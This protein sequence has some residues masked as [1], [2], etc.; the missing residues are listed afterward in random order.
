MRFLTAEEVDALADTI[1][2]RY[3][4]L[5]L[6]LG[7]CGLR[8]GE[9]LALRERDVDFIGRKVKVRRTL[10]DT[11]AGLGFGDPKTEQSTRE[12]TAP[13]FVIEALSQSVKEFGPGEDGLIFQAPEGGGPVSLT[14]FRRRA[15]KNALKATGLGPLRIHDL[16]HTAVAL[17]IEQGAHPKDIQKRMGHSSIEITMDRYGHAWDSADEAIADGFDAARKAR[18]ET[19]KVL[20]FA[21]SG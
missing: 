5:V 16:R 8:A 18:G 9:A 10:T 13:M 1:D 3:R 20:E 21:Q 15:W 19:G 7:F 17:A 4:A 6:L 2:A 11:S 12:V 14:N